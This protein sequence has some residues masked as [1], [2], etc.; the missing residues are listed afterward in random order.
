MFT[1]HKEKLTLSQI[2]V[3]LQ[4]ITDVVN[5]TGFLYFLENYIVVEHPRGYA[6]MWEEIFQW[7]KH[8]AIEFLK[9]RYIISKKRRQVGYSTLVGAYCLW[10]A[11]F[12]ETQNIN[13]VSLT[14]R[15]SAT[16]LRRVKFM[17]NHLPVWMRQQKSED[18][19]T[20]ITFHHNNSKITSL[21]RNDNPARGETLSLLVLDEFAAMRNAADVLAAGVPALSAGANIAFTNTTL[22][23]QLFIISTYPLNPINNE[24]VRLLNESRE[25]LNLDFLVIDVDPSDIPYYKDEKWHKEQLSILGERRYAIEVLGEEPIESE[26]TLLPTYTLQTLKHVSPIRCDF[27]YPDDIDDEGYYKDLTII[28]HF[29]DE[30]DEEYHYIKGLWIWNDPIPNHEYCVICDVAKGAGGNNDAF[31]V[32]DLHTYEQVAEYYNNR[33]SL[34]IFQRI[35]ELVVEYYNNAKLSIENNSM[36]QALVEYFVNTKNYEQFYFHRKS[37]HNYIPGFPMNAQTRPLSIAH[38]QSLLFNNVITIKSLRLINELRA[39]G[40][41]HN[42]AIKALSGHDDLVMCLCQFAYLYTI[43]WAVSNNS[44]IEM[45]PTGILSNNALE[46]ND[47]ELEQRLQ[48][49]KNNKIYKYWD[50]QFDLTD[51]QREMLE[52]MISSGQLLSKDELEKMLNNY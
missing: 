24:Y 15:E 23:S 32:I 43:G 19:K 33:V 37:K 49:I 16:F 2:Q 21:P 13:I 36:G 22:P 51:Q 28:P 9:S 12:F 8:A 38:M 34:Q 6:C 1:H 25:Q 46:E 4:K 29:K 44:I 5:K 42:G 35:I 31:I 11:L 18:M 48:S 26:N 30:F 52:I 17:Y 41:T 39:F 40:Y 7:Q 3:E 45:L 50:E 14:Q 27:L 47:I 10:R 20:S